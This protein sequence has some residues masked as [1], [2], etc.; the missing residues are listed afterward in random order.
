MA[1]DVTDRKLA[2]EALRE[3]EQRFREIAD[4]V[5][6]VFW[7]HSANPFRLLYINPAYERIW[8]RTRQ[9]IYDDPTSFMEGIL[10][11][12]RPAMIDFFQSYLAGQEGQLEYRLQRPDESIAWLSVRTFIIRNGTGNPVRYI[13]I[14]NDITSQKEKELVLHQSLLREQ[15][16]NQLK[17]QFVSTASHEF[18]TP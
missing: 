1:W 15:E 5:D 11:E 12:D 9:S 18:R 17:S 8:N 2:E 13:G 6:E 14:V 16:L 3:S 4:N 10:E 7:I